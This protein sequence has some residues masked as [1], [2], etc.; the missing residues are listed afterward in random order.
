MTSGAGKTGVTSGINEINKTNGTNKNSKNSKNSKNNK[1]EGTKININ[2]IHFE[3]EDKEILG[4]SIF[5]D[6]NI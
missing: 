3:Y 4:G 2:T 1:L 5:K 6:I